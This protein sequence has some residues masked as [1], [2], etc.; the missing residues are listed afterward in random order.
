MLPYFEEQDIGAVLPRIVTEKPKSFIQKIQYCEYIIVFLYKKMMSGINCLY[1]TP[2]PFSLY[3]KKVIEEIGKFD[4]SN[5]TE[6]MELALRLQK[7][8]LLV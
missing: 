4:A 3:R 1:T 8:H 2:G 7:K 6:D 5:L